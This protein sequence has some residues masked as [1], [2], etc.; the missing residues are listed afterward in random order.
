MGSHRAALYASPYL[1]VEKAG[2]AKARVTYG[3]VIFRHIPQL[4]FSFP[5]IRKFGIE[6]ENLS[7][8]P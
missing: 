5:G 6:F 1:R 3:L 4:R 7:H 8:R 2:L